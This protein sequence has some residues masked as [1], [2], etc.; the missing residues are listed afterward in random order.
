MKRS[1]LPLSFRS[2]SRSGSSFEYEWFLDARTLTPFTLVLTR[3]RHSRPD[4]PDSDPR[5]PL[6]PHPSNLEARAFRRVRKTEKLLSLSLSLHFPSTIVSPSLSLH[7]G[8]RTRSRTY[9]TP[10]KQ[11]ALINTPRDRR[12][13]V[14][15]RSERIAVW[16]IPRIAEEGYRIMIR[17]GRYRPH[18]SI[19]KPAARTRTYYIRGT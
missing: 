9:S 10:S 11:Y 13:S 14:A 1:G 17:R 7:R 3:R 12:G 5:S 19:L 15:R 8:P 18:V 4:P 6:H 16:T 2:R